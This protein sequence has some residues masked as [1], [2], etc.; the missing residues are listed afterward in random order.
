LLSV[1]ISFKAFFH[2]FPRKFLEFFSSN[3]Y[4]LYLWS[5]LTLYFFRYFF[6]SFNLNPSV[7][8]LLEFVATC[9]VI[10]LIVR[11][12]KMIKIDIYIERQNF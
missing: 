3:S 11:I 4:W 7:K 1:F 6:S 9:A 5:L 10:S 12:Q 2:A 8:L